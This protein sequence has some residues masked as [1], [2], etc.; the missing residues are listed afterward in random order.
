LTKVLAKEVAAYNIRT[1]TVVLGTFNTDMGA[2]AVFGKVPL[3]DDYKETMSENMIKWVSS[4]KVPINGDKEKAM[5]AVYEVAIGEGAGAGN[6]LEKFLPLGTDMTA[7]VTLVRDALDHSLEVF[8]EV[9]NN[10]NLDK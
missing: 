9:T 5:K 7:R 6:E 8:G 10:V 2:N 4:G 3:P 1:L